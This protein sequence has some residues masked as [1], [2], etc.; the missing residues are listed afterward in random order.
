MRFLAAFG[1][2]VLVVLAMLL[3]GLR[4]S[5]FMD[6][7]EARGLNLFEIDVLSE[8]QRRNLLEVLGENEMGSPPGFPPV[9]EIPPLRDTGQN[10][11]TDS[12]PEGTDR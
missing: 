8:T 5:G 12:G 6:Q 11:A 10:E 1:L 4:L 9:T 3:V 7:D 2:A